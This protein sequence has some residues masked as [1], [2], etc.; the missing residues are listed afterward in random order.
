L[1]FDFH[2]TSN[3]CLLIKNDIVAKALSNVESIYDQPKQE[4]KTEGAARFNLLALIRTP[5][6]YFFY[7]GFDPLSIK[8]NYYKPKKMR[9][10]CT[11]LNKILRGK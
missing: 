7:I 8:L 3:A 4:H 5:C 9:I 2:E 10:A 11:S 6:G 1:E